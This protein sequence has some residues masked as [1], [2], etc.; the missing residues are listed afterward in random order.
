MFFSLIIPVYNRPDEIKEVLE[1]LSDQTYREFEVIIVD[2]GSVKKADQ[3]VASFHQQLD[4]H[5]HYIQNCGQG[6]ARNFGFRQSRGE[7]IIILD[8]DIIIPPDYLQ[9]VNDYLQKDL[10]DCFGGPDKAH[11]SFTPVQKAADFALTSFL[12]TGGTRG[13]KKSAAA[14]YPR[15]FNM[16]MKREVYERSGGFVLPDCGEDLEFSI[17]IEKTGYRIGLIEKA[18]IYHKRKDS[19][20][21]FY[22]QMVWFGKS[23]INIHRF[24][25]E[26]LKL[27]HLLPLMFY[28]YL[29]LML[30]LLPWV[31]V[32]SLV[33]LSGLLFYFLMVWV[34]ALVRY[35]SL[36]VAI[37]SILTSASVF[38]G[39]GWGLIRYQLQQKE[40]YIKGKTN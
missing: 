39:Y 14:Y 37:L 17:R 5:Y 40:P 32:L 1:G 25:P 6:F 34:E 3:V 20:S 12:T 31:P 21:A 15:S 26:S 33:M 13:R 9:Q 28:L 7:Y 22:R 4:I 38:L 35:R 19:L 24:F 8:S 23:R 16:G 36:K 11:T 30:L 29:L 27:I 18:Y 10:L 2:D